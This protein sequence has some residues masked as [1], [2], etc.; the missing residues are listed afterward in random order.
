MGPLK[1]LWDLIHLIRSR[2]DEWIKTPWQQVNIEQIDQEL[3]QTYLNKDLRSLSKESGQWDAF[4]GIER[5]VKNLLASLRS[6]SEFRNGAIR[7]RHWD[8]LMQETGVQIHIDDQTSLEDLLSLN[9]H[10]YEE[11]VH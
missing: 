9:L 11:Q 6:V 2:I 8:E 3:R 7:Q 10:R 1:Q 4:H 5:D